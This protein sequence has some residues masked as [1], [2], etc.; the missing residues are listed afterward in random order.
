[1]IVA[2]EQTVVVAN[3]LNL[4]CVHTKFRRKAIPSEL[5]SK[6]FSDYTC[7][8]GTFLATPAPQQSLVI[9]VLTDTLEL[10]TCIFVSRSIVVLTILRIDGPCRGL[11][12]R[13]FVHQPT[14]LVRLVW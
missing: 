8:R 3:R 5:W 7:P 11:L 13:P 1:L 10:I 6:P 9:V 14:E 12:D 4:P 2:R